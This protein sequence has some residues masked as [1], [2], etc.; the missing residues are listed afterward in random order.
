MRLVVSLLAAA[1]A[2]NAADPK[3]MADAQWRMAMSSA[4]NAVN[5]K[6]L[7]KAEQLFQSAVQ[8]T[9]HFEA[10]D[11]RVGATVNGL[12]LVLKEEKKFAEAEKAFG[13]ALAIMEKAYGADSLDVGNVSFNLASVLIAEGRYDAALPIVL[14]CRALFE[15]NLGKDSLKTDSALCMAGD[16][17]RN[18]KK[19]GEA[20]GPL[21]QC[22]DVREAAGGMENTELADALFSLA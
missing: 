3:A 8:A 7:P 14:K 19:Y 5:A 4:V 12:G 11:P 17:Y 16:A 22:A 10:T 1:C 2:L 18:L 6:N 15:K 20:E 9:E 21:R 13:R